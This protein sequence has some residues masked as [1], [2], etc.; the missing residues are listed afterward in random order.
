MGRLADD[1]RRIAVLGG[2]RL[3][4]L[5]DDRLAGLVD[6]PP[7]AD[8]RDGDLG[9]VDAPLDPVREADDLSFRV[10]DGD[11]DDLR[12]EDVADLVADQL[13]HAAHLELLGQSLLD[14]VD[15]RELGS[16]LVGLGEQALRLVEQSSVLECHAEARG[17]RGE[18][19]KIRL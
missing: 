13:V 16:A 1:D 6:V 5:D 8:Q 7:E 10:V 9:D 12:V 15:D 17:E 4:V 19:P 2:L 14:A 3:E 11:V 18:E